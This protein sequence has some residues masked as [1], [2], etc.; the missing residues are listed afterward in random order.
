[1]NL[2]RLKEIL[3]KIPIT[4][5]VGGYAI[6]LGYGWYEFTTSP[7]SPLGLKMSEVESVKS[8]NAKLE[9]KLKEMQA[10]IRALDAKRTEIIRLAEQLAGMKA[11]LSESL[12]V[13]EFLKMVNTE[14]R[15]VGL[16]RIE[17]NPRDI[18]P[19]EYY[20]EHNFE[21]K[22]RG[23]Y[24]QLFVFLDRLSQ[25]QQ[26]VRADDFSVKPIG[27]AMSRFVELEGTV[28]IKAYR[29]LGSKADEVAREGGAPAG[30]KKVGE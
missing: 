23:V 16:T 2:E 21:M 18:K 1:M 6:W 3:E 15:K 17:V 14:A 7:E 20:A 5:L 19:K 27:S 26:I 8:E 13:P 24:V 22:F 12:D 10:F 25:V 29:Y 28:R 9:N 4:M 30:G 11:S